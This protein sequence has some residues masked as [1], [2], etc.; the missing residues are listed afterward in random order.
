MK[1][2][3]TVYVQ[4]TH[5]LGLVIQLASRFSALLYWLL[6]YISGLVHFHWK[7]TC[8][9]PK[10]NS[11]IAALLRKRVDMNPLIYSKEDRRKI[12]DEAS[13][14]LKILFFMALLVVVV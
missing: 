8:G 9:C 7:C 5:S 1:V 4:H 2:V 3:Y 14:N 10:D 12:I 6:L 11:N 13:S